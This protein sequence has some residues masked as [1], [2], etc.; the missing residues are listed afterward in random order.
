MR[1]FLTNFRAAVVPGLS[2]ESLRRKTSSCR[3]PICCLHKVRETHV[4]VRRRR[5]LLL[6]KYTTLV[7]VLADLH[8]LIYKAVSSRTAVIGLPT[9]EGIV[10]S[11]FFA[12]V[13]TVFRLKFFPSRGLLLCVYCVLYIL[14]HLIDFIRVIK[15]LDSDRKKA[16][17]AAVRREKSRKK[18]TN[19]VHR[20]GESI[21]R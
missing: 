15:R 8:A 1:G 9:S 17:A 10:F 19:T 6:A 18:K 16:A 11:S 13:E 20:A 7:Y 3:L 2:L 4:N 12:D 5:R 21:I 14:I